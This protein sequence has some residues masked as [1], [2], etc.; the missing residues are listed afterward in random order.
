VS[1][2]QKAKGG[3]P[4]ENCLGFARTNDHYTLDEIVRDLVFERNAAIVATQVAAEQQKQA[5]DL[6]R[7][8]A[9]RMVHFSVSPVM[10]RKEE[11]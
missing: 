9:L 3:A 4:Q 7:I 5:A 1:G 10:K 6:K 2:R 8:E 11:L